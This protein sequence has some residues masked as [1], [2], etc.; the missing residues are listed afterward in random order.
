MMGLARGRLEVLYP[1]LLALTA[2]TFVIFGASVW[3]FRKQL[4]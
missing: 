2:S 1:N 4:G 3:R